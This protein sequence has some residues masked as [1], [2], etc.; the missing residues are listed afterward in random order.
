M[1]D[2]RNINDI[3]R[4]SIKSLTNIVRNQ[5][6]AIKELN[7]AIN[8][9]IDKND[10]Q[11]ELNSKSD[12]KEVNEKFSELKNLINT[13][14][15]KDQ[16]NQLLKDKVSKNEVLFY[17]SNK[18]STDDINNILEEK[19]GIREFEGIL[20]QINILK[21]EKIDFNI[22]NSEIKEIKEILENKTNSMDVINALETKVDK[23]EL[24][25]VLK[26]L[27]DKNESNNLLKNK[28]DKIESERIYEL[29]NEKMS[30]KELTK[31][32][33]IEQILK[34]KADNKDFN[35]IK[36]AFQDMKTQF[37]QRIDDI[38]NDLDRLIENI[39][40]QFKSMSGDMK[41]L[42]KNIS[43]NSNTERIDKIL[44]NKANI[45]D[46]E[47]NFN[48]LKNNIFQSMNSFMNEVES[49]Q[50]IFEEKIMSNL[51]KILK[52]NKYIMENMNIQ[53]STLK[54]LF[55]NKNNY[56]NKINELNI[57]EIS[58][59]ISDYKLEIKKDME[60]ILNILTNKLDINALNKEI[61]NIKTG[62]E[63]KMKALN[64][65]Q[66]NLILEINSKIREMYE[67]LSKELEN[68]ITLNDAKLLLGNKTNNKEIN[69]E[70]NTFVT[71][72]LNEIKKQLKQ[73]L[74]INIFNKVINQFNINFDNIKKDIISTTNIEE[75]NKLLE[76]KISN[77]QF[78]KFLKEINKKLNEKVNT[79][80]FTASIDNQAIINDTLCNE[81]SIGRWLWNSGNNQNNYIIPWESQSVNT[82]P[83]NFI[84]EK[85]K[86]FILVNEEG[87]YEL[88]LGF[89]SDKRPSIQV[90]VNGEIII[91]SQNNN[92][93]LN[94]KIIGKNG[95]INSIIGIS[96]IEFI[97]LKKQSKIS[98][99]FYG[100]KGHGF[101]GLKKI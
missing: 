73:K 51:D 72:N 76:T 45:N 50:K 37:T 54:D 100:G 87:L 68:K 33:K 92:N 6:I 29:L 78:N 13:K 69:G 32:D 65:S 67:D 26:K 10:I 90:L 81:N 52:E 66:D 48:S 36:D 2:W 47:E 17:L 3:V 99:L 4:S 97:M 8:N 62:T 25:A 23:D 40:S 53:G 75:I 88:N 82:S 77:D 94:K 60:N 74:D 91:N 11:N 70:D 27:V 93:T 20:N 80:D 7:K 38:D 34:E 19:I 9:K 49:N 89:Y 21:N 22:F 44:K 83:D 95:D 86:T 42:E 71:H 30:N 84:W 55:N 12:K 85:D 64:E 14:S 24:I 57:S 59:N 98:V 96:I 101:I 18:A 46:I 35:L 16:V 56:E 5:G 79:I 31:F 39:K 41:I 63:N 1:T 61:S 58:K 28:A 15:S 43:E